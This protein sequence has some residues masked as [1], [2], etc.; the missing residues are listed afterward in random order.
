MSI[1]KNIDTND[2]EALGL[3]SRH[4]RGQHK[5][6]SPETLPSITGNA[7][8]Y[9]R[10]RFLLSP[11]T[12]P[13][14]TMGNSLLQG[15]H[16]LF[17]VL[18]FLLHLGQLSFQSRKLKT[19]YIFFLQKKL[20]KLFLQLLSLSSK[21]LI[22]LQFIGSSLLSMNF[23]LHTYQTATQKTCQNPRSLTGSYP[24]GTGNPFLFQGLD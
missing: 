20:W 4:Q 23:H 16:P 6:R 11:E 7:S 10:K 15:L 21:S 2:H 3:M 19:N 14:I 24:C 13:S 17:F 1:N 18:Q 12:L 8:F 5:R 9:H 22:S